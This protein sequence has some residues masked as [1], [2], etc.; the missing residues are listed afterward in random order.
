MSAR[1]RSGFWAGASR[2]HPPIMKKTWEWIVPWEM[3]KYENQAV[4]KGYGV[5]YRDHARLAM[6][7]YPVPFNKIV[8]WSLVFYNWLRSP[9]NMRCGGCLRTRMVTVR[10]NPDDSNLS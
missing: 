10:G 8:G 1:Y 5:A 6:V 4:P 3:L 9:A 7:C 2:T